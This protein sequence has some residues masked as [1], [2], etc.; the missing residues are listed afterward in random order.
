MLDILILIV[1]NF[2]IENSLEYLAVLG[3]RLKRCGFL[4]KGGSKRDE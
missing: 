1:L 2:T 4:E 3:N